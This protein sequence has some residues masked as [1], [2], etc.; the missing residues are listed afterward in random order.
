MVHFQNILKQKD[1]REK[2]KYEL[3]RPSIG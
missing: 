2:I 3:S 1:N